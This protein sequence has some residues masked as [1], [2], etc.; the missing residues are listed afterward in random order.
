M[1]NPPDFVHMDHR[2][3]RAYVHQARPDIPW[4]TVIKMSQDELS[5]AVEQA[6]SKPIG[7]ADQELTIFD[8]APDCLTPGQTQQLLQIS[9]ATFFRLVEQGEIPGAVKIGG[10]WRVWKTKLRAYMEG[11]EQ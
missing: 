11:G 9:R 1:T 4:R 10:S 3:L 2:Q 6:K 8:D 7:Q 5:E